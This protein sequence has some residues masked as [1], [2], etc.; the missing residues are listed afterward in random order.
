MAIKEII[1]KMS[2]STN[3]K[4]KNITDI[5]K[6]VHPKKTVT[7]NVLAKNLNISSG[8]DHNIIT[9]LCEM[10]LCKE[11]GEYISGGGSAWN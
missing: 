6:I 3:S 2:N 8:T 5:L 4:Q 9:E 10:G 7:K 1:Q 11:S